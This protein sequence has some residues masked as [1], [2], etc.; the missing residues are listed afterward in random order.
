MSAEE[1]QQQIE[2]QAQ[3]AIDHVEELTDHFS[4]EA[5]YHW[6]ESQVIRQFPLGVEVGYQERELKLIR[7]FAYS[8]KVAQSTIDRFVAAYDEK[9]LIALQDRQDIDDE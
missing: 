9:A 1:I 2:A 8:V 4:N 3:Q 5:E 6:F 7:D